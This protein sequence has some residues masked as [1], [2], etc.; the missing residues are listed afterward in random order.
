MSGRSRGSV[1]IGL[2][3]LT[4]SMLVFMNCL[5]SSSVR[6][7]VGEGAEG[8]GEQERVAELREVSLSEVEVPPDGSGASLSS[9]SS[10]KRGF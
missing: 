4:D 1:C 7:G 3:F 6:T 10:T 2:G 5:N 9:A 8:V